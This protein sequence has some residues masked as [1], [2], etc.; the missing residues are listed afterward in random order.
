[1][2]RKQELKKMCI[3]SLSAEFPEDCKFFPADTKDE[4]H[5]VTGFAHKLMPSFM[6]AIFLYLCLFYLLFMAIVVHVA[7]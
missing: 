5:K 4:L 1:M 7:F 3:S 6:S 2:K